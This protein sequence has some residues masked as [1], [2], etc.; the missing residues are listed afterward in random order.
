[1][2]Y[3]CISYGEVHWSLSWSLGWAHIVGSPACVEWSTLIL[4][5][6]TATTENYPELTLTR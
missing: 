5:R 1:M 6:I 3:F 4:P 2:K